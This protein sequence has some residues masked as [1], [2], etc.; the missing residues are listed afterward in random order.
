MPLMQMRVLLPF[1]VFLERTDV[2]S[3]VAETSGGFFG[4]L[5]QRLDC[6]ATLVPGIFCYESEADGERFLATDEG[7]LVKTGL[8]VMVAARKAIAGETLEELR[9]VVE[10]EFVRLDEREKAVRSVIAR[11]ENSFVRR[12]VEVRHE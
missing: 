1:E 3:I 12:F 4:I 10:R 8:E 11:L 2:S 6:V 9:E 5:P 7:V